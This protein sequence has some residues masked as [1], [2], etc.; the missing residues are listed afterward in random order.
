MDLY[1]EG[2]IPYQ[3]KELRK[4]ECCRLF[5]RRSEWEK[6]DTS[7]TKKGFKISPLS[8]D[9]D[10]TAQYNTNKDDS[11]DYHIHDIRGSCG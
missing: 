1:M 9:K 11:P 5:I 7:K 8:F 4:I 2:G 6:S 3:R 10:N